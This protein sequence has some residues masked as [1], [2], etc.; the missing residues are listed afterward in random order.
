MGSS[1]AI[2]SVVDSNEATNCTVISFVEVLDLYLQ[3]ASIVVHRHSNF[4]TDIVAHRI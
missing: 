4:D 1:K 2:Y 3:A